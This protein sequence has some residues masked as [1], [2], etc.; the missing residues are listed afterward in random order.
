MQSKGVRQSAKL[1]FRAEDFLKKPIKKDISSPCL[2]NSPEDR[3]VEGVSSDSDKDTQ[4]ANP[5]KKSTKEGMKTCTAVKSAE[6]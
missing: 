5:P 6:H 3:I 2:D 1:H 4:N